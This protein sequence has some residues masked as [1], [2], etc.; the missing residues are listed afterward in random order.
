MAENSGETFRTGSTI[1]VKEDTV[2]FVLFEKPDTIGDL[3]LSLGA[4]IRARE[5][6][7]PVVLVEAL[8]QLADTLEHEYGTAGQ[9]PCGHDHG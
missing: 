2:A 8:R 3:G 9:C 5:G 4:S 1:E 6:L 7:P